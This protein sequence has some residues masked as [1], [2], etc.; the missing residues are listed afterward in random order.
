[1]ILRRFSLFI[2]T[3]AFTSMAHATVTI[4]FD[5]PFNFGFPDGLKN[6]SGVATNGMQWG[7]V[8]STTDASFAGSGLAYDAYTSGAAS[9]GFLNF[10]G[11][12]TDDY[13]I[14]GG[15]TATPG[16]GLNFGDGGLT[17]GAGS[18]FA[19]ITIP[20]GTNNI[21]ATDKFALVWFA[22]PGNSSTGGSKYG[23]FNDPSFVVGGDGGDPLFGDVF[24]GSLNS[25][26]SAN[27]TFQSVGAAPEPS[28]ALLLAFGAVGMVVRRRRRA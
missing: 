16:S 24:D 12:A 5:D 18:I 8:V 15:F 17:A 27:G 13:Y 28:R 14:P 3:V 22:S 10:G 23:F 1:M 7:V 21:S 9:A 2:A 6:A 4:H 20:F 11:T 25:G 26:L 19:P